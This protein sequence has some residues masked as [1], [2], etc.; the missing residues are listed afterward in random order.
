MLEITLFLHSY[1]FAVFVLLEVSFGIY[2]VVNL[3]YQQNNIVIES[4]ILLF[5]VCIELMRIYLGRKGNLTQT[6]LPLILSALLS[7]PS[8]LAIVYL[9]WWQ[10]YVLWLEAILC[11]IQI[12]LQGLEFIL[13]IVTIGTFYKYIAY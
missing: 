5:L 8:V 7:G 1:F 11:Y 10:T 9:I 2:K 4:L 13:S 12:T 3:P 6:L